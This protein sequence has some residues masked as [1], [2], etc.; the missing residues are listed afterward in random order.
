MTTKT[1]RV[2]ATSAA[3]LGVGGAVVGSPEPAS[4]H[5]TEI[6]Y[7]DSVAT[8]GAG[9]TGMRVCNLTGPPDNAP[10]AVIVYRHP[11]STVDRYFGPASYG[12]CVSQVDPNG[13]ARYR[14][15]L[16]Y[17]TV[18]RCSPLSPGWKST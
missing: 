17:G 6:H 5:E 15:C 13:V 9:H 11:G 8:I 3:L 14:L 7:R 2:L 10:A 1:K 18:V 4:A 12:E 16:D